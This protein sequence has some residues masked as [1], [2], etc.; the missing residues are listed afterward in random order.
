MCT[1]VPVQK[2]RRL[3]SVH[4]NSLSLPGRADVHSARKK[5]SQTLAGSLSILALFLLVHFS[6]LFLSSWVWCWAVW[7]A[8]LSPPSLTLFQPPDCL[9]IFIEDSSVRPVAYRCMSLYFWHCRPAQSASACVCL[10][11]CLCDSRTLIW[12][13]RIFFFFIFSGPLTGHLEFVDFCIFFSPP[14]QGMCSCVPTLLS[15]QAVRHLSGFIFGWFVLLGGSLIVASCALLARWWFDIRKQSSFIQ[16]IFILVLP[17]SLVQLNRKMVAK[18]WLSI[19]YVWNSLCWWFQRL[20][21]QSFRCQVSLI[22][23]AESP[24]SG[25]V[26]CGVLPFYHCCLSWPSFLLCW[27]QPTRCQLH[28]LTQLV[29]H[30]VSSLPSL[31]MFT[32]N[33]WLW[34][35]LDCGRCELR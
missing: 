32:S 24:E 4:S 23:R 31:I 26:S 12:P 8:R 18:C 30:C 35:W 27:S 25:T 11:W 14:F 5:K 19:V 7:P 29:A 34:S 1:C 10:R 15:R 22:R 28:G 20:T 21:V 6:P 33:D 13:H 2:S 3:P 9:Q 17:F 16:L